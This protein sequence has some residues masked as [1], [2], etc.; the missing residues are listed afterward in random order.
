MELCVCVSM[1][2]KL[3]LGYGANYL[4]LC[5]ACAPYG[6]LQEMHL[7]IRFYFCTW[8]S[9]VEQCYFRISQVCQPCMGGNIVSENFVIF[10]ERG[11]LISYWGVHIYKKACQEKG[12]RQKGLCW[13]P[14]QHFSK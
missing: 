10:K 5:K 12:L 1:N 2:Q 3:T 8:Q 13:Q 4:Q 7:E 11:D 9:K 14:L 6:H